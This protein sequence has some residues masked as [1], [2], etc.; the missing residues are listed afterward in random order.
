[1]YTMFSCFWDLWRAFRVA[2]AAALLFCLCPMESAL[3]Q[4]GLPRVALPPA[5][6]AQQFSP[7]QQFPSVAPPVQVQRLPQT[8][9]VPQAT[10]NQPILG[11]TVPVQI[12]QLPNSLPAA[13][14]GPLTAPASNAANLLPGAT[15]LQNTVPLQSLRAAT[16]RELLRKHADVLEPDP[17][18]E[19]VRRQELLWMS[20]QDSQLDAALAA[21]FVVLREQTLVT[22]GLRQIVLRPPNGWS[23]AQALEKLRAL[24]PQLVVDFNHVYLQGGR[25]RGNPSTTINTVTATTTIKPTGAV[26]VGLV[27]GGLDMQ[28]PALRG[29]D[30]RRWGCHGASVPSVHGTA[31]ASLLVGRAAA[32]RA[33]IP[34]AAVY[35]ADIYCGQPAGGA[36]ENIASALEWLAHEKLAVIN[37]SLVGPP[38]RL[39]EQVVQAM[40]RAGHLLV[41]AVGN[42]GPAAPPLYPAT[43][44]GVVGVTAVNSHRQVLPEAAQ[45][46]QVTFAALGADVAVAEP[47]SG[48]ARARGTSFAAPVVAGL[49]AY[50]MSLPD[51]AAARA[52]LARLAAHAIDLG[53][54]GRDDVFGLGL[55]EQA[56]VPDASVAKKR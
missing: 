54:P 26:R 37:I 1:M 50:D 25:M 4:L 45:G 20:P 22:L 18:G 53:A 14:L 43:Y 34:G 46:A 55:V 33:V 24:A 51:P 32:V 30:V 28:H 21:G 12:Q 5:Q 52:A 10:L 48:Y 15:A 6:A 2:V 27:D 23:T 7:N 13:P 56:A 11:A 47:A 31:V 39:L 29:A 9:Q 49:L 40:V 42:D 36:A 17:N 19:P 35:S 38:N 44:P 41:A 3:A 8:P 16:A